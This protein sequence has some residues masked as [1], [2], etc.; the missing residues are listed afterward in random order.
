MQETPPDSALH[1]LECLS[2]KLMAAATDD[3]RRTAV[4][5]WRKSTMVLDESLHHTLK[6]AFA[7]QPTDGTIEDA[8]QRDMEALM[9][10]QNR[11]AQ[12]EQDRLKRCTSL[13]AAIT[14]NLGGDQPRKR[15]KREGGD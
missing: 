14:A 12:L 8:M 2:K 1:A 4:T 11:R 15:A 10:K 5:G 3:E 9:E 13:R 6:F 7:K